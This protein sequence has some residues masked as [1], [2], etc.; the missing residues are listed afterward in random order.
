VKSA[1]VAN[2]HGKLEERVT[3]VLQFRE[4]LLDGKLP[5]T[6]ELRWPDEACREALLEGLRRSAVVRYCKGEHDLTDSVLLT[7]LDVV[8]EAEQT[9]QRMIL[10]F[11][12]LAS[13][14]EAM[15]RHREEH[16]ED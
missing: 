1:T 3:A 5:L 6:T 14:E 15:R 13:A 8:S 16:G 10:S 7:V 9:R 2:V 4:A 12:E 11:V